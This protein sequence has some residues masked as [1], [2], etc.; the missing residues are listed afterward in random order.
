MGA[1]SPAAR[2]ALF[3]TLALAAAFAVSAI[4]GLGAW[5]D[6]PGTAAG[7]DG[8][9]ADPGAPAVV[10]TPAHADIRVE[11]LN[12]AGKAGLAREVTRRLRGDGFDVVFYGNAARFDHARSVVLDRVGD[13]LRARAVA[14]ALRID[15]VATAPDSTLLLDVSVV[16]GADWPPPPPAP[17]GWDPP[18]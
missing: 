4:A 8:R 10:D 13:T 15:S 16:M 6:G 14:T 9:A 1:E 2:A 18:W 3:A 17:D 11:V 5:G 12:G 7:R